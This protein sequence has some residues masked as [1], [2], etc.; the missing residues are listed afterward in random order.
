M[1]EKPQD[2]KPMNLREGTDVL[3]FGCN[4]YNAIGWMVFHTGSG[5]AAYAV[6]GPCAFVVMLLPSGACPAIL[7][8][9]PIWL[10]FAIYRRVRADPKEHS[11][12]PGWFSLVKNE[13]LG[14][15]SE[16][17]FYLMM[18][19]IISAFDVAAGNI[20][21]ALCFTTSVVYVIE[22]TSMARRVQRMKDAQAEMEHLA[23][24]ARR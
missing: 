6:T 19:Y 1:D 13:R 23:R 8:F 14:K 3:Y 12:Y 24:E 7:F 15:V 11:N 17:F 2:V 22:A 10:G 5:K 4:I 9:I 18:G 16:P 21:M 20:V